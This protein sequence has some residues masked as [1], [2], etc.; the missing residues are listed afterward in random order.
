MFR[1]IY[2]IAIVCWNTALSQQYSSYYINSVSKIDANINQNISG[3]VFEHKTIR[4]IDYGALQLANVQ[5]ERNRIDLQK[6]T[7]ERQMQISTDISLDPLKAFDYGYWNNFCSD[8]KKQVSKEQEAGYKS[9]THF[10]SFCMSYLVPHPFLFIST[11]QGKAQNTSDNG[12]VTEIL[13]FPPSYNENNEQIDL[14]KRW[15]LENLIVGQENEGK[16]E[17]QNTTKSY[18]H[19]KELNRATVFGIK[20][21][22][23]TLILEDDYEYKITDNYIS[24][25]TNVGNGYVAFVKVRYFG[26][27]DE[28][29][30][31]QLEGRRYYLKPL[32]EKII[33]TGKVFNE[34]Y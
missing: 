6:Y 2:L 19:K 17:N 26:D 16:D 21:Y 4:T 31:E 12:I 29:D 8:D 27:K 28:I 25:N 3:T 30:F 33:S 20:G 34:K 1:I 15:K 9:M 18:L 10:K 13:M 5:R 7:D 11:S 32:I 22:R 24:L 23:S 14:E